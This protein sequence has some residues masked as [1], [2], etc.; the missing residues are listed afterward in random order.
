MVIQLILLV[1][2]AHS[3]SESW[4]DKYEETRARIWQVLLLGSTAVMYIACIVGTILL[5]VFYTETNP[6][7]GK[8]SVFITVNAFLCL[9]LSALS[10]WPRV[11]YTIIPNLSFKRQIRVQVYFLPQL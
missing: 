10:I 6:E 9:I 7:C 4:V 3:W 5:Y 11:L 2:F 1:D 8:N